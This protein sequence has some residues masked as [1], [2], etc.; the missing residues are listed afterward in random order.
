MLGK[1]LVERRP[2]ASD[3]RRTIIAPTAEGRRRMEATRRRRR[4]TTAALLG[5]WT[6]DDLRTFAHLLN[7]HNSAV[8]QRYLV[9]AGE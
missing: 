4:D 5:D 9:S 3:R 7:R 1:G 8:A 6:P 2:A